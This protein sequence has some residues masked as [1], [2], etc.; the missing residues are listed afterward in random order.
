[1]ILFINMKL[2]S[3]LILGVSTASTLFLDCLLMLSSSTPDSLLAELSEFPKTYEV[4]SKSLE[5]IESD[6]AKEDFLFFIDVT[7]QPVLYPVFD[8]LASY[9]STFYFSLSPAGP[10]SYSNRRFNLH[11]SY[12]HQGNAIGAIIKF[13]NWTSFSI[14]SSNEYNNFQ[15]SEHI[16]SESNSIIDLYSTYSQTISQSNSDTFIGR[17]LKANALRKI[18][19]I[20]KS[21]SLNKIQNSIINRNLVVNGNSF[22]LPSESIYS[23]IIDGS[24]IVVEAG[25][26]N[27][28]S[29]DNYHHI[30]IIKALSNLSSSL[31]NSYNIQK[32]K[33]YESLRSLYP[34][35]T[36]CT[37]YS[38]VNLYEG[39]KQ[40]VGKI[41][42]T[43]TINRIIYYPGNVTSQITGN[44][45]IVISISNTTT[46]IYNLYNYTY[47]A[48]VNNG[49]IFAM[50]ESNWN[51]DIEGYYISL[52]PTGC[53]LFLYDPT[54]Y[55][56]CYS[57][58]VND[59]G[60]AYINSPW[61]I[62]SYGD[63]VTL[64]ELGNNIPQ[65]SNYATIELLDNYE[66]FPQFLDIS[67]N[68]QGF[69]SSASILYGAMKWK[70]VCYITDRGTS[71]LNSFVNI[72]SN[73]Y[74]NVL[75]PQDKMIFPGNYSRESFEEYKSFFQTIKDTNCVIIGIFVNN[76]LPYLEGFYDVGL[77]KGDVCIISDLDSIQQLNAEDEQ[78]YQN[79]WYEIG[80]NMLRIAPKM[81][82][83]E[84]GSQIRTKMLKYYPDTIPD[85]CAS[86]DSVIVITSAIKYILN[87]GD[88]IEDPLNFMQ[89]L[90]NVKITGCSGNIMFD[91]S[92]NSA[93]NSICLIS[94]ARKN[95][96]TGQYYDLPIVSIDKFSD[97]VVTYENPF[98]WGDQSPSDMR[99]D[100]LC[101]FDSYLI[102]EFPKGIWI[103]CS[104]CV[105]FITISSIIGYKSF[106][107]FR[108]FYSPN[109]EKKVITISDAVFISYF[110]FQYFQL[111]N[112]GP[113]YESMNSSVYNLEVGVSINIM[114]Y[115]SFSYSQFWIYYKVVLILCSIW[116][117]GC[118][119]C[120]RSFFISNKIQNNTIITNHFLPAIGL[121]LFVPLLSM[122]LD[123]YIC[124]KSIGDLLTDSFLEFDC[125]NFC[126]KNGHLIYSILGS[127]AITLFLT[128]SIYSKYLWELTQNSLNLRTNPKYIC[129]FSILQVVLVCASKVFN[130]INQSLNGYVICSII[131]IVILVTYQLE[132]YNDERMKI[133]QLLSLACSLFGVLISTLFLSF[134]FPH[135]FLWIKIGGLLIIIIIG[136]LIALKL[137]TC[138]YLEKDKDISV[139]LY[140][141]F[142]GLT[143]ETQEH[144]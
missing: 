126:Y 16:I 45:E 51:N 9:F 80:D 55:Y 135:L 17:L 5:E 32:N 93:L 39:N 99:P 66:E 121:I 52:F 50:D 81:W 53:G 1:M 123:I 36:T 131:G 71:F 54:W 44:V 118:L 84:I 75:N 125:T 101:P 19:I 141:F 33:I 62:A 113:K 43:L 69:A 96:S 116:I 6:L 142:K 57:N 78:V 27:A 67:M 108:V 23:I 2:G 63:L 18:I 127:I 128:V 94:Q 61:Y 115:Y 140:N 137:E 89:S 104:F 102:K 76:I 91:S 117:L 82:V 46:E 47:F 37:S 83:G 124:K 111:V 31:S 120:L 64:K 138:V 98:T 122:L 3:F 79:K 129:L 41:Q 85:Y 77:R 15:L 13:L 7:F 143:T 24:L 136:V 22:I 65:L 97:Q 29:S 49:A 70:Y 42:D 38:L 105:F 144:S 8:G 90:R 110:F 59:M 72:S 48:E 74:V 12:K 35:H 119:E 68:V 87:R 58:V 20:D 34:D 4:T 21:D 133:L 112:L 60:V 107:S 56:N 14:V 10:D 25:L 130:N 106:K 92:S 139:I 26:E 114:D 100:S 103:F 11:C 30:A 88:D 73:F 40:I 86:Y 132:P 28:T 95:V 134:P 109:K